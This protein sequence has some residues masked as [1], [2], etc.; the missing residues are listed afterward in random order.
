VLQCAIELVGLN[1]LSSGWIQGIGLLESLGKRGQDGGPF[2]ADP[3][4]FF[5]KC[6]NKLQL[7]HL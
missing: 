6:G 2:K 7:T 4:Q 1:N 3:D 5:L